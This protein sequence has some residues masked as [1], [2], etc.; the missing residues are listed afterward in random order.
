MWQLYGSF[1]SVSHE[2]FDGILPVKFRHFASSID[3][4][5]KWLIFDGPVDALWI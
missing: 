4:K 3:A 5:R 2:W 1:D